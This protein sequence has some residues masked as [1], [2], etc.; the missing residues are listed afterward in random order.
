MTVEADGVFYNN[1]ISITQTA[2]NK[3][4]LVM[5]DISAEKAAGKKAGKSVS[6][7]IFCPIQV[8]GDINTTPHDTAS[9]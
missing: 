5:S 7:P 8:M 1:V 4:I 2:P 3:A 9:H 6:I